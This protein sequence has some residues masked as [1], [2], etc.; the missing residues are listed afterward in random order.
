MNKENLINI[1][2]SIIEEEKKLIASCLNGSKE[3]WDEFVK[4]YAKL[5]YNSIYRTL[6]LKG[7]ELNSDLI[8][9]LWQETFLSFLK[10]NF[11][12][13]RKFQWK[14]N[15]SIAT[16]IS[17]ITRNLILDF[18]RKESKRRGITESLDATIDFEEEI[19]ILDIKEDEKYSPGQILNRKESF[20]IIKTYISKLAIADKMLFELLF[21]DE[22]SHE[23][24]AKKLGK[25]ID[26]IYMQKKRLLDKLREFLKKTC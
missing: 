26:A 23:E 3:A 14:N 7:Y 13:L 12:K 15:C 19:T 1:K 6:E 18:I 4:K 20:K 9:D 17:V 21:Y 25:S 10:N 24:I 11:A 16:W 8:E 22:L 5:I 2:T